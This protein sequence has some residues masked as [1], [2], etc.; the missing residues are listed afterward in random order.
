MELAFPL[1]TLEPPEGFG[2]RVPSEFRVYTSK[3]SDIA[4]ANDCPCEAMAKQHPMA[5]TLEGV[6]S[7]LK[8]SV[9]KAPVELLNTRR[10]ASSGTVPFGTFRKA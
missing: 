10:T 9:V 5:P 3:L 2:A 7:W 8:L 4:S 6:L 1:K